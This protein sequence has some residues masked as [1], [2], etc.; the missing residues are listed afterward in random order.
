MS[1]TS[2]PVSILVLLMAQERD[3]AAK[4]GATLRKNGVVSWEGLCIKECVCCTLYYIHI[5]L[6]KKQNKISKKLAKKPK[7]T[8]THTKNQN[9][10][11]KEKRPDW[12]D[13]FK[14]AKTSLSQGR[15]QYR[16]TFHSSIGKSSVPTGKCSISTAKA[17]LT[18]PQH[19]LPGGRR[20]HGSFR[21][22]IS[23]KNFSLADEME[24]SRNLEHMVST[25]LS[26]GAPEDSVTLKPFP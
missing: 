21:Q 4:L 8:H 1:I 26:T 12:N 22:W 10:K 23:K 6:S 16:Q 7:Q 2:A 3:E 13:N 24:Q 17:L 5:R 15:L 18:A 11:Q 20:Q 25:G 9:K 14:Q 19:V